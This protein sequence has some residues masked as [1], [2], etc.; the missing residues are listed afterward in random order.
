[1]LSVCTHVCLF[2][3]PLCCI[4]HTVILLQSSMPIDGRRIAVALRFETLPLVHPILI[5]AAQLHVPLPMSCNNADL[6]LCTA[7]CCHVHVPSR[8]RG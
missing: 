4:M 7:R 8:N 3:S 1:M 2:F 6:G 5:A